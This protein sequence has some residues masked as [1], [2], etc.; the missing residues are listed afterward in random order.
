MS[1]YTAPSTT[2]PADAMPNNS[3]SVRQIVLENIFRAIANADIAPV[4]NGFSLAVSVD[5][6]GFIPVNQIVG[7]FSEICPNLKCEVTIENDGKTINIELGS[8]DKSA[9]EDIKSRASPP[10][11]L[12]GSLSSKPTLSR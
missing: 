12:L 6:L 4:Q 5:K 3:D 7:V 11:T 1:G 2:S 9:L 8:A 10:S